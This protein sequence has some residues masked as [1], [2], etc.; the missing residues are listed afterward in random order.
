MIVTGCT[1][2]LSWNTKQHPT[3]PTVKIFS[4]SD[5]QKLQHL[6]SGMQESPTLNLW[7]WAQ[8]SMQTPSVTCCNNSQ[9]DSEGVCC[10]VWSCD[11][12]SMTMQHHTARTDHMS[13]CSHF[14]RNLWT[15][16][17]IVMNFPHWIIIRLGHW[18]KI[19]KSPIP[20]QESGNG[21]PWMI[22]NATAWFLSY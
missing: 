10:K 8:Q 4:T 15:I 21:C 14:S 17:P 9:E 3:S 22:T 11:L 7:L 18:S 19:L 16:Y 13:C 6:Y 1:V 2:S 12:F 20:Q 5:L